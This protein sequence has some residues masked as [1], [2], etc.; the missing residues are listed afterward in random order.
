MALFDVG[1]WGSGKTTDD[2]NTQLFGNGVFSLK[3][4]TKSKKVSESLI[5]G[6][7]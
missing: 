3:N 2:L 1:Q 5:C 6:T 4:K 7:V